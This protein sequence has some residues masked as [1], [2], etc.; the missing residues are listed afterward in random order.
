LNVRFAAAVVF[1]Y[2]MVFEY[3]KEHGDVKSDLLKAHPA[4]GDGRV[5]FVTPQATRHEA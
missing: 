2:P 3:P 5:L 4:V 1:A